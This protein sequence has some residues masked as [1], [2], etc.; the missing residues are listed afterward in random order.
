MWIRTEHLMTARNYCL[1]FGRCDSG[2][3]I[4]VSQEVTQFEIHI[5]FP[6]EITW[7][8]ICFYKTFWAPKKAAGR[9]MGWDLPN[10]NHGCRWVMCTE[11]I[12]YDF[13]F[14][15]LQ[16]TKNK[17]SWGWRDSEAGKH[18]YCSYRWQVWFPA[19]TRG[20]SQPSGSPAPVRSDTAD[21]RGPVYTTT[22]TPAYYMVQ[23]KN[24]S[25]KKSFKKRERSCLI[26]AI[27][28]ARPSPDVILLFKSLLH[29]KSRERVP[30]KSGNEHS[31]RQ[32]EVSALIGSTSGL[33]EGLAAPGR[34]RLGSTHFTH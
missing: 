30:N 19:P 17:K 23:N 3:L 5:E 2:I 22:P 26:C 4:L 27:Y 16:S 32:E 11:D 28:Q 29:L 14:L 1:H 12:D 34:Q 15:L 20:V 21:L 8:W 13:F 9:Q 24:K 18:T 25:F 7:L 33:C 31:R 6:G 10:V